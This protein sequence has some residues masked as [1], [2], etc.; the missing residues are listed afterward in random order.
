[1]SS[2]LL[3]S[4]VILAVVSACGPVFKV[5]H[6][7]VAKPAPAPAPAPNRDSD[8]GA[9][10]GGGN[11]IETRRASCE[12]ANDKSLASDR[13]VQRK[14]IEVKMEKQRVVRRDCNGQVTS[15]RMEKVTYPKT[16]IVITPSKWWAGAYGG[17]PSSAFNRTTCATPGAEWDKLLM[18]IIFGEGIGRD[19][20]DS[21]RDAAGFPR[22]R[23]SVDTSPTSAS[24]HVKK[25]QDNY[26]DYEFSYCA[27]QDSQFGQ[28]TEKC[29]TRKTVEKGTLILTVKY[30][31]NLDIG[32]VKEL[33]DPSCPAAK[34]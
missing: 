2:R 25:N 21:I 3:T 12:T 26:I 27:E 16:D 7:Q 29:K 31:E 4:L 11:R 5:K 28:A 22:L 23:F 34:N 17:T 13:V 19:W 10:S 32:G 9:G 33:Q 6:R 14:T 30:T 8:K 1:M 15:D 18:R 20:M 24:M